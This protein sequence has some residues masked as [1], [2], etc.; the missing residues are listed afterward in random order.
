MVPFEKFRAQF[1]YRNEVNV[2]KSTPQNLSTRLLAGLSQ[3]CARRPWLVLF[4]AGLVSIGAFLAAKDM[5]VD[6]TFLGIV[7]ENDPVALHFHDV[8]T[9]YGGSENLLLLVEAKDLD[10]GKAFLKA[11]R[12]ELLKLEQWIKGVDLQ[13]TLP[14]DEMP[15]GVVALPLTALQAWSGDLAKNREFYKTFFNDPGLSGLAT[16]FQKQL[17]A[18]SAGQ[19]SGA[20]EETAFKNLNNLTNILERSLQSGGTPSEVELAEFFGATLKQ[21]GVEG[22]D[23]ERK[24]LKDGWIVSQ[25]GNALMAIVRL[26][27]NV[28]DQKLGVAYFEKILDTTAAVLKKFPGVTGNYA[29][30]AAYGFEDQQNVLKRT[31]L[32]SALSLLLVLILFFFID[33]S[34]F[35]PFIVGLPLLLGTLWT[36]GLVRLFIGYVSLTSA[37]FGILLFGL[38]VDFAIHIVVRYNDS[39]AA[40]K[41]HE[42]SLWDAIVL[43]GRG[44]VTGGL[45]S[46][47]A[48]FGILVTDQKAAMHLGITTGLGLLCCLVAMLTVLPA[49][50]TLTHPWK[51][52]EKNSSMNI[53]FLEAWVRWVTKHPKGVL[54]GAIVLLLLCFAVLPL[55]H[56]EY[57]IEKIA[58]KDSRAV[59][60]KKRIEELFEVN[61]DFALCVCKDV[62]EAREVTRKLRAGVESVVRVNSITD[63]LPADQKGH[64]AALKSLTEQMAGVCSTLPST[65]KKDLSAGEIQQLRKMLLQMRTL[66][67]LRMNMG[68]L[69]GDKKEQLVALTQ[70]L[71]HVLTLL[72]EPNKAHLLALDR[73]LREKTV[74]IIKPF[75]KKNARS[76]VL[77]DMP[78]IIRDKFVDRKN[79]V[80]VLAYPKES[81]LDGMA[82]Q[83][84]FEDLQKVNKDATGIGQ[85]VHLFVSRTLDDLPLLICTVSFVVLLVVGLDFKSF[86]LAFLVFMPLIFA[87]IYAV[88]MVIATGQIISVLMLSGFPLILGIG[89]DDGVHLVHRVLEDPKAGIVHA[90]TQ[91]GKAILMTSIT[92]MVSFG[93]L[94]LMNHHGLEGL[95]VLVTTGVGLCFVTSVTVF[96][97]VLTL[98]APHIPEMQN[99]CK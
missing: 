48:F 34:F 23:W 45:T 86:R 58:T 89:V 2:D 8:S 74:R 84:F 19:P 83:G 62:D 78:A 31:R 54:T 73:W 50:L 69:E 5:R 76:P 60:V 21:E 51:R 37:V 65:E 32:L 11:L 92:T 13:L 61:T 27:G 30:A 47:T 99:L 91:T 39:R 15:E 95:G 94:L 44:V 82:I 63:L 41:S 9:N 66:C 88:G 3:A 25:N 46:A 70:R 10:R 26:R 20:D 38:G 81:M 55:A 56:V 85:I 22:L 96:P 80:I 68:T 33:R 12:P 18:L 97:A 98:A 43:T 7:N 36:F 6:A 64:G 53:P 1:L 24:F 59:K 67:S 16:S 93:G 72:K 57:D 17:P 29:G 40:S 75:V 52:I 28:L 35:G 79:R 87:I 90:V 14:L 4:L 42:D 71:T 77:A 49:L